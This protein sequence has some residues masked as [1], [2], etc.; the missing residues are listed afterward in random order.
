[1]MLKEYSGKNKSEI[2]LFHSLLL[3]YFLGM[4]L[5]GSKSKL[6]KHGE[7]LVKVKSGIF[8]SKGVGCALS[9]EIRSF[10]KFTRLIKVSCFKPILFTVLSNLEIQISMFDK[11]F[12]IKSKLSCQIFLL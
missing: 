9:V 8:F 4:M 12:L 2:L 10:V 11:F 7:N 5:G 3:S 6:D 1:M